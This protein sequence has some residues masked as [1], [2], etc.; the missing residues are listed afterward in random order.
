[1]PSTGAAGR[2]ACALVEHPPPLSD[3]PPGIWP[4]AAGLRARIICI[5]N[6]YR[7]DDWVGPAVLAALGERAPEAGIAVVD[8]GLVGLNLLPLLDDMARVVFVDTLVPGDGDNFLLPTVI[9]DPLAAGG[10]LSFDHAAGLAYLLQAATLAVDPMPRVWV[11]GA[12]ADAE[13]DVVPPLTEIALELARGRE[14]A[15]C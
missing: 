1:M 3:S 7:A 8:G 9:A 11:V 4:G 14:P 2:A 10:K 5:G 15:H 12:A 6:P 13:P